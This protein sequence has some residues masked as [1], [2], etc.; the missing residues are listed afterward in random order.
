MIRKFISFLL[1]F[2]F[3]VL[4]GISQNLP[5]QKQTQVDQ[6]KEMIAKFESEG[7]QSQS[8]FY[9]NKIA[10]I[11]RESNFTKEA[12]DY[13]N[14]SLEIYQDIGNNNAAKTIYFNLGMI[15]TDMNQ[16]DI[17]LIN[18]QKSLKISRSAKKSDEIASCLLNIAGIQ[19]TLKK[20]KEAI[21]SLEEAMNLSN[22]I[23]NEKLLRNC[24][25]KLSENYKYMGNTQKSG[26]YLELYNTYDKYINKQEVVKIEKLKDSQLNKLYSI[27]YQIEAEKN[28]TESQLKSTVT[29]LKE[30]ENLSKEQK[31]Q[32]YTLMLIVSIFGFAVLLGLVAIISFRA[33]K[34]KKKTN[35]VL[36][37]QNIEILQQKE[38]IELQNLKIT[39]SIAY[40]QRIQQSF[41][42]SE[43]SLKKHLPESFILLKPRDIVSG[44]FYWFIETG[45]NSPFN[46]FNKF[47]LA[48]ED[49]FLISAVD[50][51]GHGVPGAF[52]SM[53]AY[54]QL[55]AIVYRGITQTDEILNELH[56]GIRTALRQYKND[57]RD[58]MDMAICAYNKEQNTLDYSGAKNPLIYIKEGKLTIIKGNRYP[59]GGIQIEESRIFTKH[60]VIID[61]P[62]SFY[63]FS[64]GFTD[65]FGGEEGDKFGIKPFSDL[66]LKISNEK[67]I[68]QKSILEEELNKWQGKKFTQIDDILIMGFQ[69]K[70][71]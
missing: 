18:Y 20:Y 66:L 31:E 49:K 33:Y 8:A 35:K 45:K 14:Q 53:I 38:K 34:Q 11:Y 27:T 28:L 48:Q 58:G 46:K 1:F 22:E 41:L 36:Q 70:P 29:S 56:K 61:Q 55:N 25:I 19:T 10:N 71:V 40:A 50:C 32:I 43:E 54:N 4:N 12:I 26:E 16:F 6:Y 30:Y 52:M 17:A 23:N 37:S 67:M 39:D 24:Y 59:I 47:E 9:L 21:T 13:F 62:T 5:T 69:I 64:D 68:K 2:I 15:Y 3:L 7:N 63:I 51:T 42:S 57:N 60:T 44:D 65:Q